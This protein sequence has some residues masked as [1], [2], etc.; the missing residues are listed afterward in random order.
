[1]ASGADVRTM[2]GYI[3]G[4]WSTMIVCAYAELG[5]ADRLGAGP[6]TVGELAQD[7]GTDADAL[8][9]MLRCA[10]VLGLH[11]TGANGRLELTGLGAL[12][13]SDGDASLRAVARLNGADYRHLPW[14]SLLEYLGTG[15]GEGLSPT[16]EHGSLDYLKHRPAQLEIFEDAMTALSRLAPG[17]ANENQVIARAVDFGQYSRIMD[18]GCGNGAL[19]TAILEAHPSCRGAMFDLEY[20]LADAPVPPSLADRL[21]KV[22]GDFREEIP[23]GYDAYLIKNVLHN[24]PE[25]RCLTLLRNIRDAM[26]STGPATRFHLFE[27][28]MPETPSGTAP[29]T[30]LNLNLLVDGTIR[31]RPEMTTLLSRAGLEL[32]SADPL[33]TLERCVI[34]AKLA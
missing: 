25:R 16:W 34:S 30:D 27:F 19:L 10:A 26:A 17:G 13:A 4:N 29:F 20:V 1:V 22:A 11:R 7:T 33:P 21:E 23:S 32:L 8:A 24:H 15:S 28:L 14:G 12:L 9:R 31:T 18:V 3:Y 2:Y 5:I 6:R